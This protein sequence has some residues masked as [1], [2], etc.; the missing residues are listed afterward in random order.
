MA[1]SIDDLVFVLL[2]VLFGLLL[3]GAHRVYLKSKG[4]C[5]D[6]R[7][8]EPLVFMLQVSLA[9]ILAQTLVRSFF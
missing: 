6:R 4:R 7:K 3:H 8:V 9:M 2:F 5:Y 1:F